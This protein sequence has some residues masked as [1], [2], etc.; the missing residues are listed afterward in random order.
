MGTEQDQLKRDISRTRANLGADVDALTEHVSPSRVMQR[1]V[2]GAKSAMAGVRSSVM[3]A[4]STAAQQVQEGGSTAVSAV[5]QGTEGNPLAAG[6]VAFGGA[7]LISSLIPSTKRE[8]Q[9]STKAADAVQEHAE[10][11]KDEVKRAVTEGGADLKDQ[12]KGAVDAV[13]H[14]TTQAA[15]KVKAAAPASPV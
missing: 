9:L 15:D 2:E 5:R 4:P 6:L 11:I 1:K 14:T 10:P 3:G 8:Q 12:A 13:T 7:W